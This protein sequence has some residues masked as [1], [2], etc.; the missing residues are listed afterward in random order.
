MAVL[1]LSLSSPGQNT[2]TA[3]PERAKIITAAK[4][5]MQK[6]RYCALVTIGEDGYPQARV[7]DPFAPE[8]GMTVWIMQD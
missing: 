7:V 1:S 3:T 8:E 6:A 4:D 5:V 2:Q